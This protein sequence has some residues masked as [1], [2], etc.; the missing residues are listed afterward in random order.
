MGSA[1]T[2][3]M[4]AERWSQI[5]KLYHSAAALQADELS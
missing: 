4:E 5:E 3:D 2:Y 1:D